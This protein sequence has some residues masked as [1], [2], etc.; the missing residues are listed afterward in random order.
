MI[1]TAT[2][3]IANFNT[4]LVLPL[5]DV[6]AEIKAVETG[7]GAKSPS[8]PYLISGFT[9]MNLYRSGVNLW[10][11]D[12]E[13]GFI[14]ASGQETNST[15]SIRSKNYCPCV[16]NSSIYVACPENP[17]LYLCFYDKNKAFLSRQL[18]NADQSHTKTVPNNAY[19]FRVSC[20]NYGSTYSNNVGVN[21]P[22]TETAYKAYNG[23][24]YPVSWQ[25]EVGEVFGGEADIT[26]GKLKKS[27]TDLID[28]SDLDWSLVTQD[29]WECLD[30]RA[31]ILRPSANNVKANILCTN[32]ETQTANA[33]YSDTSLLGIAIASNGIMYVRN[34]S[35]IDKPTG[36]I[37]YEL[38]TPIEIDFSDTESITAL[39][40]V[41]N[42]WNDTN[43]DTTVKY[44]KKRND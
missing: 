30:V 34:G 8:N 27:W 16:P 33:L 38:A 36:H 4:S 7:T 11:E 37:T 23:T 14:N 3:A 18:C 28:L 19:Y 5:I 26:N 39:L 31:D 20:Y 43:G 32:F 1:E 10:D 12:W 15:T 29:R 6:K 13:N 24:T 25:T 44:K 40:G 21:Y 35:T 42:I 22:S 2:G 9:G 17:A 41:N